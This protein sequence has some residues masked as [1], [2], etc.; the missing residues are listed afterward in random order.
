MFI[1]DDR[2]EFADFAF[3][4]TALFH[5]VFGVKE[6][7]FM[8]SIEELGGQDVIV[9]KDAYAHD[10]ILKAGLGKNI[11]TVSTEPEAIQALASGKGDYALITR[12]GGY[13]AIEKLRI[14]N[15]YCKSSPQFPVEYGFAVK[16][17]NGFLLAKINEALLSAREEGKLDRL[18]RK[19]LEPYNRSMPDMKSAVKKVLPFLTVV[20][21]AAVFLLLWLLSLRKVVL[22]QTEEIGKEIKQKE[23]LNSILRAIRNINQLIARESDPAV[24]IRQAVEMLVETRGYL[25][26]LI[27]LTDK[28]G[29]PVDWSQ[30]GLD[31]EFGK[32]EEYL[33]KENLPP[34]YKTCLSHKGVHVITEN[35]DKCAGCPLLKGCTSPMMLCANLD[36]KSPS[37]GLIAVR[38]PEEFLHDSEEQS[39][40]AEMAGDI[41]YALNSIEETQK[42]YASEALN[43]SIISVMPDIIIMTNMEGEY[44]DVLAASENT[45][46]LPKSELTGK[47]I[48]EILPEKTA[49]IVMESVREVFKTKTMQTVEY[50]LETPAGLLWFEARI[51]AAEKNKAVALIRDITERKR[52]EAELREQLEELRRWHDIT[53]GREKRIME[54]KKV[55]NGLLQQLGKPPKYNE[56]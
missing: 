14:K 19:W 35:K 48:S 42:R 49:G 13:R 31:T 17:G 5:L 41:A 3:A 54:L 53:L 22:K 34:C 45:L 28:K 23:H 6:K 56:P 18:D 25:A 37:Y 21:G 50:Q 24:L 1:S 12:I 7:R 9:Q 26:A 29:V 27:V 39:L 55:I 10:L 47:K 51:M 8:T 4:N 20:A 32:M 15:V 43:R 44:L 46:A 52:A 36:Y 2:K 16:K 38:L 33:Q 11:L 40:F 30:K